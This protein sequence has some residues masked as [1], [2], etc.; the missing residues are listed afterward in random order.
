MARGTLA[1]GLAMRR[2]AA[3]G[4]LLLTALLGG[5]AVG[6]HYR[7][8]DLQLPAQYR[9]QSP[10]SADASLGDLPWWDLYK[11]EQ[12]HALLNEALANNLDVRIAAARVDEARAAL[13]TSRLQQLPQLDVV[14]SVSRTRTSQYLLRPGQAPLQTVASA[15]VDV[16]FE[17]DLWGRLRR[18]SEAARA[19]LLASDYAKRTVLIDLV[20]GVATDYFNL[21]ALR[22]Q[23]AI[24]RRTV[25]TRQKLL[26]LTRAKHDSGTISGL[27]VASVEAQLAT[28]RLAI[29][30]QELAIARTEEQ[31]SLLLGRYP[32]AIG[33]VS[34]L[35]PQSLAPTPPAG[36]PAALLGRRPDVQRAEQQLVAANARSGAALAALLPTISLTGAFGRMSAELGQLLTSPG[37]AWSAGSGLLL[38]LLDSSRGGYQKRLADARRREAELGYRQVVQRALGEVADALIGCEKQVEIEQAQREQVEALQR[39][40][41]IARSRYEV[42]A[43]SYVDVVN[44]DRDLFGAELA[45]AAA[46]RDSLL[47]TVQLYRALGGGWQQ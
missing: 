21:G 38:P 30:Q 4:L 2:G 24:T 31:L 7:R 22:E 27:D 33:A 46:R 13:G 40:S 3:V 34:E 25:A 41:T 9:F 35:R 37:L 45:L 8:P 23:L 1:A 17:L 39:A 47:T 15:Q 26:E 28:A 6:R 14:G 43:A 42:G 20:S 12:L 11:D 32:D 19:D 16:G 10:A 44:A 5:C 36:L 18:G 29:P